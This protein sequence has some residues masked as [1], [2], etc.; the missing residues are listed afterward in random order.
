MEVQFRGEKIALEEQF[1]GFQSLP[2]ELA[3]DIFS[4]LSNLELSKC[5]LVC[6]SWRQWNLGCS[7]KSLHA[8][9]QQDFTTWVAE[10]Y[11]DEA[12]VRTYIN[13]SHFIDSSYQ[14]AFTTEK[15]IE[16]RTAV[17]TKLCAVEMPH[18][19]VGYGPW[20]FCIHNQTTIKIESNK[21]I[22]WIYPGKTNKVLSH[23]GVDGEHLFA[24]RRDGRILQID[25]ANNRLVRKIQTEFLK[26]IPRSTNQMFARMHV[27]DGWMIRAFPEICGGLELIPISQIEKTVVIA[28]FRRYINRMKICESKLL[29]E[30]PGE[31]QIWNLLTGTKEKTVSFRFESLQDLTLS[32]GFLYY[33]NEG[34][35]HILDTKDDRKLI[36][37]DFGGIDWETPYWSYERYEI[38]IID[39]LLLLFTNNTMQ[40]FDIKTQKK[41]EAIDVCF[42]EDGTYD[43]KELMRKLI[44]ATQKFRSTFNVKEFI[45]QGNPKRRFCNLI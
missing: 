38:L 30:D 3:I 44:V 13:L 16:N 37:T 5:C 14:R 1:S 6:K 35:L 34:H 27:G 11:L 25:Y 2:N 41:V 28:D 12:Q 45:V 10:R 7:F 9:E 8:H 40:I 36:L 22:S 21:G 32:R 23:L 19:I 43:R 31:I 4:Y 33:F 15:I 39:N 24:L 29:I 26:K 17:D 42:K 18:P 20:T